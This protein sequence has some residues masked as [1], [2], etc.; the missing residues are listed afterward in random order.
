M[1][2]IFKWPT[3]SSLAKYLGLEQD[4]K[5]LF[6]RVYDRAEKQRAVSN[7]Q[8]QLAGRRG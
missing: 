3:V 1:V 4:D 8:R 6:Q 2:E 7:R 5:S